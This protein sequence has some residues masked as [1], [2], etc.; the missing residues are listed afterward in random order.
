MEAGF[1][2]AAQ[3]WKNWE[4]KQQ[5]LRE[6]F[7]THPVATNLDRQQYDYLRQGMQRISAPSAD[8][9][10][11]LELIVAAQD[12][13]E[14]R[15]YPNPVIRFFHQVKD[16]LIT[17]PIQA[18]RQ[19]RLASQNIL[20]LEGKLGQLGFSGEKL[21]LR[22]KL[23][24]QRGAVQLSLSSDTGAGKE[25][26]ADLKLEMDAKGNYQLKEMSVSLRDPADSLGDRAHTFPSSLAL[27]AKDAFHLL[28]GRA[29][30]KWD[31]Y[32]ENDRWLQL[33]FKG[34]GS[35]Q[36]TLRSFGAESRFDL[37]KE[38]VVLAGELNKGD[39]AANEVLK[40][41]EAG[42]QVMAKPPLGEAVFLEAD[43]ANRQ[44]LL[45]DAKQRPI[46]LDELKESK[47]QQKQELE[48]ALAPKRELN[49]EK[50]TVKETAQALQMS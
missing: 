14:R 35:G 31:G 45:R 21:D 7:G 22:E 25:L 41:L 39:L 36:G 8:E 38:L 30:F 43:P 37:K 42:K 26:L 19:E 16:A 11:V 12:K 2:R 3:L 10:M 49:L 24:Y 28:Q 4:Q 1:N 44:V 20:E 5:M 18:A 13:L 17:G 50:Q 27:T 33:D 6:V 47:A 40:A 23:D 15:L 48:N 46:T 34:A 9:K 29:V 32:T